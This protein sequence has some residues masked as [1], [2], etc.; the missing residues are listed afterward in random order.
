M[1]EDIEF[2]A[3]INTDD[4]VAKLKALTKELRNVKV[5]TDE[6]NAL[7]RQIDD[8]KDSIAGARQGA[9]N[10]LEVLG[11]LPGPIGTIGS[12]LASTITAAKQFTLIKFSTIGESI[13]ELGKDFVDIGKNILDTTGITKLYSITNEFLAKSFVKVGIGEAAAAAGAK[14]F[15]AALIATGIGAIIVAIGLLAANWDKVSDAV[16]GATDETRAYDEA[17]K[18]VTKQVADFQNKLY[19]VQDA[20]AKAKAGTISKEEALK[21]Y[22]DTLGTT[23]GYAGS[24]ED[25]EALMT[26]NT[27]TVIESI[28]LRTQ[29]QVFYGKAAE[30]AARVVSGEGLEPGFWEALG[31]G[32]MNFGNVTEAVSDKTVEF[33][34]KNAKAV[35]SLEAEGKRLSEAAVENDKKLKK[36]LATP[37]DFKAQK[38][39][40][41]DAKKQILDYTALGKKAVDETKFNQDSL[42]AGREKELSNLKTEYDKKIALAK[43][44]NLDQSA[45]NV[46]YQQQILGI[47]KKYN[48]TVNK[49]IEDFINKSQELRQDDR[50]KELD[51]A[52]STYDKLIIQA[53][54]TG[55]D[56]T[57][58]EQA[59]NDQKLAINK[60]HDDKV[61]ESILEFITKSKELRQDDRNKELDEAK[62]SYDKLIV[63]ATKAG[64]DTTKLT[65]AYD[66]QKLSINKKYDDEELKAKSDFNAKVQEILTGA[67]TND[68]E[69]EKKA[70]QDKL[71]KD[72][73]DLEKDKEFIKLSETEK[74]TIRLALK[75]TAETDISDIDANAEQGRLDKKLRL[76]ELNGQAL[77]RGTASYYDN[78]R[79]LIDGLE[80]KELADLKLKH[81][82]KLLSDEEFE[83][84]RKDIQNKYTQQKKE[85]SQ[86]ELNDYLQFAGQIL[87]A[88]NGI[89]SAA[90]N[91]QKMQTEQ[92]IQAAEGNIEKIEEI[93]KKAFEDNKKT[94]IA[95]AIIGT[96][97]S[98]IQSYQSLAVIP[99]VGV[100][101]GI[102][103]AAAALVFGYKQVALI[104]AQKYQSSGGGSSSASGAAPQIA[105]PTAPQVQQ[106]AAPQIKTGVAQ[107]PQN[108]IAQTLAGATQKPVEAF[109][110]S[111]SISSQQQLD[112]RT[113]RAATL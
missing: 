56:T 108:Q 82:K 27:A 40:F 39:A 87:G 2:N 24:L 32:V 73:S 53:N 23:I 109:V 89:F 107:N 29:A 61:N 34:D 16:S 112:R 17:Q 46:S 78:R 75:Q 90:S 81:D 76:L 26:A 67:I 91:V 28:K 54:Q 69:R 60:K 66:E 49:S 1:A 45:I 70:R 101:L 79:L 57:K 65:E 64:I 36:G 21:K 68:V 92:D 35:K 41:D 33:Y 15:S 102:A 51:E 13:V 97:Q 43:Q 3:K 111:T 5:G 103:A 80:E 14:A 62:A 12:A 84:A 113:N 83:K 74:N 31:L 98:A 52:K 48:D 58:L 77:L 85:L 19:G 9:G 86:L 42:I 50:N 72:L 106:T 59:Y 11:G 93:K 104:K 18:E 100:G 110:V 63:E 55:Q 25:A 22:N 95:Q 7:Q 38:G 44:F 99:V 30:A 88:V 8:T 37:P 4:S 96:L 71:V 10:F 20:F 47:N 105:A 6:F 94:Q